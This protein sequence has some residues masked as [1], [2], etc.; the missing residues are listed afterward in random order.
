M[1]KHAAWILAAALATP[2]FGT[3]GSDRDRTHADCKIG[4]NCVVH[5]YTLAGAGFTDEDYAAAH[6]HTIPAADLEFLRENAGLLSFL[7]QDSGPFSGICYFAPARMNLKSREE[8]ARYYAAWNRALAAKS[9][10]PLEGLADPGLDDF[11]RR[12][13]TRKSDLSIYAA[14]RFP[15]THDPLSRSEAAGHDAVGFYPGDYFD[16]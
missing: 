5:V 14:T 8:F 6:G 7:R 13:E 15:K 9:F 4:V 12:A 3:A 2:G 11:H 1:K 16:R 10:A